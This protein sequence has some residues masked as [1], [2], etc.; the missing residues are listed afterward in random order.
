MSAVR[1]VL[2]M[3]MV[4]AMATSACAVSSEFS[5]PDAGVPQ[6]S[7]VCAPGFPDCEDTLVVDQGDTPTDD[8]FADGEPRDGAAPTGA[9]GVLVGGGLTVPGALATD[10]AGV[11]AVQGF[12]LDDGTGPRLGEVLAESF[13]PQCGGVS[14]A[15]GDVTGVGPGALQRSGAVTWSDG[16]VVILGEFSDGTLTP[17][18]T[19]I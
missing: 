18:P 14:F 4:V 16:P 1:P 7:G 19:S 3:M 6:V 15:L 13:P 8:P 17:I 2:V 12:Y 11:L 9:A 5:D 10:T